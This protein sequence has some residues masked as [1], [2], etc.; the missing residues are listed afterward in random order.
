[1]EYRRVGKAR[2][3]W[4]EGRMKRVVEVV[5]VTDD[6]REFSLGWFTVPD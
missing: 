4:G 6:N 1:V 5:T 2:L 3:P